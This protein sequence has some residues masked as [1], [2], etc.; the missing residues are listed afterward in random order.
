MNIRIKIDERDFPVDNGIRENLM[1]EISW[2]HDG[3]YYPTKNWV[4]FGCIVLGWWVSTII[5]LLRGDD[6][7]NFAFMDGPY[8]IAVK[9]NRE[10]MELEL[11]P[12][13][14]NVAW[15]VHLTEL[16]EVMIQAISVVYKEF[17]LREVQEED[18]IILKKYSDILKDYL[19]DL[20]DG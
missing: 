15:K 20:G 3:I 5:K 18:K 1:F 10:S 11:M 16:I 6:E 2:E 12:K 13:G 7:G 17:V 4:D 14:I 19:Q 9:I 8:A